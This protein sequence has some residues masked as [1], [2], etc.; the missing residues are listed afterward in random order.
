MGCCYGCTKRTPTCHA[1]CEDY[2]KE[3][4]RNL[5]TYK[6]RLTVQIAKELIVDGIKKVTHRRNRK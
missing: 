4:Q 6:K 5:E 3:F 2:A 1:E